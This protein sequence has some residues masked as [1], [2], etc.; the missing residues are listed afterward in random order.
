MR[1]YLKRCGFQ[2]LGSV[3]NGQVQRGRYLLTS[4]KA[5]DFFPPLSTAQL[6]DSVLLPIVPLYS[7]K[8][9]Y[10]TYVYHNDEFHGSLAKHPRNEYRIYLNKQLENNCLLFQP[11]DIV[12][13]RSEEI[14][15][16]GEMQTVFLLDLVQDR[17]SALYRELND[18]INNSSIYGGYGIIEDGIISEF[19]HKAEALLKKSETV[20]AID[21]SV[22][23]QIEKSGSAI[24]NLFNS[25]SFRD[26][27]MAGYESLCAVTGTVICYGNYLNLEAAH[28]KP[29]S[30]GGLFMP[31]NG[32]AL[33]RD[34]HWAFDKGFFTLNKDYQIV[35]HPQ[36]TSDF[37]RA[38]D[39][40]TIRLPKEPFFRPALD[41]IA[42]HAEN[43]YGLFL[44]SGRL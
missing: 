24:A 42:Y 18:K 15:D 38:F 43:I 31:N 40:K 2:E 30:H 41:N 37:L 25:V 35:V 9:V 23:R 26:F 4:K 33:N 22:T 13:I 44:T 14:T 29:K 6:N 16:G 12:I 19:E 11:D 34:M 39:G 32:I 28:I 5:L 27:V 7:A 36:A 20:V 1:Y 17:Q 10:C 21:D 3:K 8:K